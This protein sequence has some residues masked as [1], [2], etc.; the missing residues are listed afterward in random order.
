MQITLPQIAVKSAIGSMLQKTRLVS[1]LIA[2]VNE[3]KLETYYDVQI[4]QALP[5][6]NFQLNQIEEERVNRTLL[7]FIG[8][9]TKFYYP[10]IKYGGNDKAYNL[11]V[12]NSLFDVENNTFKYF[13]KDQMLYINGLGLN[14]H[15]LEL[16]DIGIGFMNDPCHYGPKIYKVLF[17]YYTDGYI[18]NILAMY[19]ELYGAII[20]VHNNMKDVI[21]FIG[22]IF[23]PKGI[24]WE[25]TLDS[26]SYKWISEPKNE[27][28]FY[29]SMINDKDIIQ[30]RKFFKWLKTD[31]WYHGKDVKIYQFPTLDG[32]SLLLSNYEMHGGLKKNPLNSLEIKNKIPYKFIEHFVS[33]NSRVSSIELYDILGRMCDEPNVTTIVGKAGNLAHKYL[34]LGISPLDL[35]EDTHLSYNNNLYTSI[36]PEV[37]FIG[38]SHNIY[39]YLL[40]KSISGPHYNAVFKDTSFDYT[41]RLS[42][43]SPTFYKLGRGCECYAPKD[44]GGLYL[45]VNPYTCLAKWNLTTNSTHE[46]VIGHIYQSNYFNEHKNTDS[47]N[48]ISVAFK[49]GWAWFAEWLAVQLGMYGKPNEL[50]DINSNLMQLP[51]FG[52]CSKNINVT[53]FKDRIE[54]SN[55]SYWVDKD[56]SNPNA[57]PGNSQK[58]FDAL[59]YFGFLNSYLLRILRIFIDISINAGGLK[60]KETGK[61]YDFNNSCCF[62]QGTGWSL[63]DARRF[64]RINS[65]LNYEQARDETLEVFEVPGYNI[66]FYA[67]L[68]FMQ[69]I[70]MKTLNEFKKTNPDLVF[71]DW[72]NPS[73]TNA[74][75]SPLFDLILQNDQVPIKV[76]DDIVKNLHLIDI[77]LQ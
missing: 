48:F 18:S 42:N 28:K 50:I 12:S 35:L 19:K 71:L 21:N 26:C 8:F 32:A 20:M 67:G 25:P 6:C 34:C 75:T 70:Y 69:N 27:E 11:F 63:G 65:S 44:V 73:N 38:A 77:I 74:N 15:D 51:Q 4:A 29:A 47:P 55:G 3:F 68:R 76:L 58:L 45:N 23:S 13:S 2:M 24:K 64:L 9:L 17:N 72:N 49:E 30:L 36:K 14:K 66:S 16:K 43:Y 39:E 37:A 57:K 46:G 54:F 1:L 10:Q 33:N 22:N 56:F 62:L 40:F 52:F 7:C 5:I 61:L 53:E 41:I 31:R 60:F 59:Q